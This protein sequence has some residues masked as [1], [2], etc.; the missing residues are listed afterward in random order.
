M[1]DILSDN[2]AIRADS[3]QT[4]QCSRLPDSLDLRHEIVMEGSHMFRNYQRE[5]TL[6]NAWTPPS[7]NIGFK[8]IPGVAGE[9]V[10]AFED[11]A[12]QLKVISQ[13]TGCDEKLIFAVMETMGILGRCFGS[14]IGSQPEYMSFTAPASTTSGPVEA[15]G[16][17]T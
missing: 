7:G 1:H 2:S 9:A 11:R 5:M 8:L 10:D 17:R 13:I 14:W 4:A 12:D 15:N 16:P 6:G 3:Q